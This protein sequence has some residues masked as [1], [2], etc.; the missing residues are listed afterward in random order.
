MMLKPPRVIFQMDG[1]IQTK[2]GN[3][4]MPANAGTR[5]STSEKA[6]SRTRQNGQLAYCQ[7]VWMPLSRQ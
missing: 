4:V 7:R 5:R 1:R 3:H 2:I 6:R